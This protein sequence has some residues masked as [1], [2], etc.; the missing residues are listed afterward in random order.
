MLQKIIEGAQAKF[1]RKYLVSNNTILA[2]SKFNKC[3]ICQQKIINLLTNERRVSVDSYFW[4]FVSCLL[5]FD[6]N[7]VI[8]FDTKYFFISYNLFTK[9]SIYS[10]K[11][12]TKNDNKCHHLRTINN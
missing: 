8:S 2:V 6:T 10:Q 9:D 3:E 5:D 7:D 11:N 1:R 12:Y 4:I